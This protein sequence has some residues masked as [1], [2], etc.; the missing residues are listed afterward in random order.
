MQS[1]DFMARHFTRGF[2]LLVGVGSHNHTGIN[3]LPATINDAQAL[4]KIL[5]DQSQ[6]G[7]FPENVKYLSANTATKSNILEGLDWLRAE[8]NQY[9]DSTILFYFSGHG[10]KCTSVEPAR[11]YIIP[12]DCNPNVIDSSAISADLLSTKLAAISASRLAVLIDAC[13]SGGSTKDT[14]LLPDGYF[15]TSISPSRFF[16]DLEIGEGRVVISSSREEEKSFIMAPDYEQSI[17]TH[18]LLEGLSGKAYTHGRQEIGI[19]DLFVH[20]AARVPESAKQQIDFLTGMPA[21][22]HPIM[23]G[24]KTDNFPVALL[25]HRDRG[26]KSS[27]VKSR[28]ATTL[29][30][31]NRLKQRRKELKRPLKLYLAQ[32]AA[33]NEEIALESL[34]G[35]KLVILQARLGKVNIEI[36]R[37]QNELD[38]IDVVLNQSSEK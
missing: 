29:V 36:E 1:E 8:S 21:V 32:S 26:R 35:Q 22:Q 6:C 9:P 2:A 27:S 28:G 3:N 23:D 20:L 10:V 15:K 11:Y 13:H 34:N 7:Y 4:R 38:A 25:P 37:I 30:S 16:G 31:K 17:F 19:I 18:H 12:H 14:G 5:L 24:S 33:I